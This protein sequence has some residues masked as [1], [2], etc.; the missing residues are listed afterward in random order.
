MGKPKEIPEVIPE[1][2]TDVFSE[3]DLSGTSET[4]GSLPASRDGK[5]T[6]AKTFFSTLGKVILFPSF[7]VE[8]MTRLIHNVGIPQ[9]EL[10]KNS[11]F[12]LF[13]DKVSRIFYPTEM[14]CSLGC[15]S[16]DFHGKR[17][18]RSAG[19]SA[20][21]ARQVEK[22]ANELR[23]NLMFYSREK[24]LWFFASI[25]CVQHR[26]MLGEYENLPAVLAR[27]G[28]KFLSYPAK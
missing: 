19:F 24:G 1:V 4:T 15:L 6:S 17:F 9:D 13:P 21:D 23:D 7:S 10:E 8:K 22:L 14:K 5:L 27:I 12:V 11:Q 26:G 28:G 16:Q 18:L 3:F 2:K 25:T 20:N